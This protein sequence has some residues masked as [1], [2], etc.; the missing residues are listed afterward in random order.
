MTQ[1]AVIMA[2]NRGWCHGAAVGRRTRRR[3]RTTRL[4]QVTARLAAMPTTKRASA[5]KYPPRKG[6]RVRR[7][8]AP[9]LLLE[10]ARELFAERGPY[11]TTTKQIAER[12]KVSEDLIFR[13][14]ASKNGL[15]KEAVFQ[16]MLELVESITPQW[17]EAQKAPAGDEREQSRKYVGMLYDL[18]HG[19]R[20]I[21]MSMVQIMVGGPGHLDDADVHKLSSSLYEPEAPGFDAY[22]KNKG[23][24]RSDPELQLRIIMILIGSTAAFLAGTYPDHA[25]APDRDTVIEELVDFIHYGLK[26]PD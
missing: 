4:G 7:G 19:N 20:T 15:L 6:P 8:T 18:V 9:Q 17:V 24:R 2:R 23:L 22:L 12:A 10:A 13:Y 21:V 14:F 11:A 1:Q 3:H 5:A 26:F 16:P 25:D